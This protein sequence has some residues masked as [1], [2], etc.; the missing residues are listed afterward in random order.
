MGKIELT[1]FRFRSH[2]RQGIYVLDGYASYIITYR[3]HGAKTLSATLDGSQDCRR[4]PRGR[5]G[6]DGAAVAR[7]RGG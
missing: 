2:Y 6:F 4:L 1:A 7:W 3:H 5:C